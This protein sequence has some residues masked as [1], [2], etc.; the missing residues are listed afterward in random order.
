MIVSG[1]GIGKE[2]IMIYNEIK[3]AFHKAALA[4]VKK[5]RT[6]Q[7]GIA[8]PCLANTYHEIAEKEEYD[9]HLKSAIGITIEKSFEAIKICKSPRAPT[10]S[11]ETTAPAPLAPP[12]TQTVPP[13]KLEKFGGKNKGVDAVGKSIVG[14]KGKDE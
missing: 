5:C 4:C 14:A 2:T 12:A 1:C 6:I 11:K 13:A 7:Y 9:G 3:G 10:P 8:E